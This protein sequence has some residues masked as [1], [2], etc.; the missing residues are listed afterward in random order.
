MQE[1]APKF[2]QWRSAQQFQFL[3]LCLLRLKLHAKAMARGLNHRGPQAL[4]VRFGTVL[5]AGAKGTM[6]VA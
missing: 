2:R 6:P 3:A 1:S 5:Q 4:L